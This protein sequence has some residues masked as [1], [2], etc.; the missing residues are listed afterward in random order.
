M[1]T[2]YSP[3]SEQN[4][5]DKQASSNSSSHKSDLFKIR[6][7]IYVAPEIEI[8]LETCRVGLYSNIDDWKEARMWPGKCVG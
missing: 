8:D 1:E 2:T 6:F 3:N 7:H 5:T 4:K